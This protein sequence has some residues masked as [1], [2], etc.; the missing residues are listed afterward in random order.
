MATAFVTGGTGFLGRR[1]AQKLVEQR[2]NV[3]ALHRSPAD[4]ERLR[5]LGAEPIEGDLDMDPVLS[6]GMRDGE[7]F[8]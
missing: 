5:A 7:L 1:L 8:P 4:A 2:W 3:R 6:R